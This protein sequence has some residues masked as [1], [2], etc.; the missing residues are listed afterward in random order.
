MHSYQIIQKN[1]H[2]I[3][4]GK[5]KEK[6]KQNNSYLRKHYSFTKTS[7]NKVVHS[8]CNI[9]LITIKQC[10]LY[11]KGTYPQYQLNNASYISIQHTLNTN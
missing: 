5:L 9:P 6:K 2:T 4:L 1:P 11:F 10:K 7:L 8:A 3:L